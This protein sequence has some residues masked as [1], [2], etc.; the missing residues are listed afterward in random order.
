MGDVDETFVNELP[1]L[2]I[3]II[4]LVVLFSGTITIIIIISLCGDLELL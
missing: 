3:N 2:L 1:L 4:N